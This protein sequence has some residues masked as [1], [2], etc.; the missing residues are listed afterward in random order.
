MV[1]QRWQSVLLLISSVVMIL[2]STLSL[3]QISLPDVELNFTALGY[4]IEGI[5]TSGNQAG[6]FI[7]TWPLFI[8]SILGA[9]IPLINI[10]LFKNFKLQ[11]TLCVIEILFLMALI[12]V[13][14]IYGYYTIEGASVS[15]STMA[16]APFVA[17]IAD[18][19]AYKR[20]ISDYNKIRSI[21][22]I[23]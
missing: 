11:K 7:Q 1:I 21:D 23:R 19:M 13:A 2:F 5:S 3:G 12:G 20:I 15:W 22:R 6:W 18:Y 4:H 9:T 16:F 8:L 10:F 14:V 17:L